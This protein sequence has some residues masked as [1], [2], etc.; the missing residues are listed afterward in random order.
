MT[1]LK[2]AVAALMLLAASTACDDPG[3]TTPTDPETDVTNFTETFSGVLS[4]NGAL[5]FPFNAT[6]KGTA[7]AT[8]AS[9]L[10][11]NTL[12]VGFALGTWN[13]QSCNSV[14]ANDNAAVFTQIAGT[15]GS[16]GQLCL[17]IYD[18]GRVATT[19]AFTITVVHP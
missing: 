10:P 17:R 12:A 18:V 7:T 2:R 8:L 3:P 19:T 14:I 9:I 15:V 1:S 4:R 13:G 5:T 6:A 16:A 11:D